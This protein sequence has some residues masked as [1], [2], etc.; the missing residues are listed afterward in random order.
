[1]LNEHENLSSLLIFIVVLHLVYIGTRK[2]SGI[3][4]GPSCTLPFVGDFPLLIGGDILGTFQK[5]RQ[6]H[7]DIFS[8]YLGKD[9]TIVRKTATK[10]MKP[11]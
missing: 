6:K 11:Q 8:L 4:P 3:P 10:Y 7:G 5:L 1:M 2:P 9:L